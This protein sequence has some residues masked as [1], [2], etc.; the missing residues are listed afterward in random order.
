MM[1][2]F[3]LKVSHFKNNLLATLLQVQKL[4]IF[5]TLLYL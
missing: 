4:S 1:N 2:A 3:Y 5:D